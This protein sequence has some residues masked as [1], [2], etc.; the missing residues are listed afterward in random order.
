M[1]HVEGKDM[2]K[3]IRREVFSS[4]HVRAHVHATSVHIPVHQD[5]LFLSAI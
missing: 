1:K 2:G 3:V 5:S 4:G